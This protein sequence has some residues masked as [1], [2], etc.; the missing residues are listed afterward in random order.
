MA[1][2]QIN[3]NNKIYIPDGIGVVSLPPLLTEHQSLESC[4]PRDKV[5]FVSSLEWERIKDNPEQDVF[6]FVG[7]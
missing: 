6:Y 7:R 4:L 1:V 5:R 3:L 2:Q